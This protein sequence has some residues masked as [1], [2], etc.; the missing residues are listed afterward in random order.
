MTVINEEEQ[1]QKEK[2]INLKQ[3]DDQRDELDHETSV[4][5]KSAQKRQKNKRDKIEECSQ[6]N[7]I[8]KSKIFLVTEISRDPD[9]VYRDQQKVLIGNMKT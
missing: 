8:K 5:R 6:A 9:E 1:G 7:W 3:A 2:K 4:C